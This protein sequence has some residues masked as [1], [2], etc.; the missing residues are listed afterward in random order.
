VRVSPLAI[1]VSVVPGISAVKSAANGPAQA[2]RRTN[3]RRDRECFF[4][5]IEVSRLLPLLAG[6]AKSKGGE[7][8]STR[9]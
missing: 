7:K 8:L 3:L 9:R 6:D 2:E 5:K 4:S 1:Q